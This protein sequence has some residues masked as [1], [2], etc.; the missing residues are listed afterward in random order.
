MSFPSVP[1]ALAAPRLRRRRLLQ[2]GAAG[3][4][5]TWLGPLDGLGATGT[6]EAAVLRPELR[7]SSWLELTDPALQVR[8]DEQRVMGLRLVEIADLPIAERIP[9]LREHDAAFVA[10]F[11][12]APG[13]AQGTRAL[14]Q[15]ELG[16]IE[17]FLVPVGA[18]GDGL[19]EAV[20]DRTIRIA[21][22]NEEAVPE[23]VVPDARA[24][25]P[26][27]DPGPG[28]IPSPAQAK[29]KAKKPKVLVPRVRR[30][31]VSRAAHAAGRRSLV[32]EL[33]LA[34]GAGLKTVRGQLLSRGRVVAR[35]TGT[36]RGQTA[37][38]RFTAR[39]PLPRGSYVLAITLISRTGHVT[40]LRKKVRLP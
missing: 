6:A 27:Q 2:L 37:R 4:A 39:R 31:A 23:V 7:R 35:A 10:R 13:L 5:A 38:L 15:S 26:P 28:G 3:A 21:G 30:I 1:S 29:A 11:A 19:Y 34:D 14:R 20:V 8:I 25:Q 12:G 18:G 22:I 40:R 32:A 9:A 36:R 17:L 33:A 24:V 16:A